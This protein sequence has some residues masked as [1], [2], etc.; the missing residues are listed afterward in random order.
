[1]HNAK[2]LHVWSLDPA[3][4]GILDLVI[5]SSKQDAAAIAK[6]FGMGEPEADTIEQLKD[7]DPIR[8]YWHDMFSDDFD[9]EEAVKWDMEFSSF[10]KEY[11]EDDDRD[12]D[13][14]EYPS[15]IRTASAWIRLLGRGYLAMEQFDGGGCVSPCGTGRY[16][17][18]RWEASRS[19]S[20][21]NQTVQQGN[22][23]Q[24]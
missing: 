3:G 1:M 6:E 16:L 24:A 7:E 12:S 13:D 17:R 9:A 2:N 23:V 5:A 18:S 19:G 8:I 15:Q 20:P 4:Y 14:N 10:G 11:D 21:K 22:V